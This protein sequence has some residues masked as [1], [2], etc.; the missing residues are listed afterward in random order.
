MTDRNQA[1]MLLEIQQLS[2]IEVELNLYL[3]T[4]PEDQQALAMYNS[5]HQNLMQCVRKYES[6]YGPLVNFGYSPGMQNYWKWVDSPWPWEI[7]Y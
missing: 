1:H 6:I 4:H 3:D 5:T 7:K 2:F